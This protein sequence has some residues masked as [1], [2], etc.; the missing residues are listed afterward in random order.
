[1]RELIGFQHIA[2]VCHAAGFF[3]PEAF[4]IAVLQS[5]ALQ[6]GGVAIDSLSLA[7]VVLSGGLTSVSKA[8]SVGVYVH[9]LYL[10]GAR[11]GAPWAA[12]GQEHV[13]RVIE[14]LSALQLLSAK[15]GQPSARFGFHNR[16]VGV[17]GVYGGKGGA[18]WQS[19]IVQHQQHMCGPFFALSNAQGLLLC[20]LATQ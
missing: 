14:S 10:E 12:A 19:K 13:G 20:L 1:M 4:L 11:C 15:H 2:A 6:S 9:G 5:H 16:D 7:H 8:R 18:G 3:F 17:C